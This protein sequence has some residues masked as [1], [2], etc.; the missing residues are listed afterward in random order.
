M[1]LKTEDVESYESKEKKTLSPMKDKVEKA[2]V[3]SY[4][5]KD[6]GRGDSIVFQKEMPLYWRDI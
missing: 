5:T 4:E 6:K 3:E 2:D 1:K